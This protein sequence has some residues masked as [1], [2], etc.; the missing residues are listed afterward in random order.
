MGAAVAGFC[1]NVDTGTLWVAKDFGTLGLKPLI[2]DGFS[3]V[4]DGGD[5]G[6]DVVDSVVGGGDGVVVDLGFGVDEGLKLA[7]VVVVEAVVNCLGIAVLDFSN[8]INGPLV[9]YEYE[10]DCEDA[11][12]RTGRRGFPVGFTLIVSWVNGK[13]EDCE[14]TS[15]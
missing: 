7:I 2:L 12:G 6:V 1:S 15:L 5:S 11:V 9:W 13:E 8:A 3:W 10:K 14:I 4:V